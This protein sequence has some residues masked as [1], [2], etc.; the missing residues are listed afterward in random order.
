[1]SVSFDHVAI[2]A[3][4]EEAA[5]QFLGK[6]L[7]LPVER[8]GPE[9]EMF[10]LRLAEGRQVLFQPAERFDPV[11]VAFRVS[12]AELALVVERLR[13]MG[14]AFGNDPEAPTNM[15]VSDPLGGHGRVY[16]VDPNR[17]LFEVCA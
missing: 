5:A 10:C 2:P 4:D 3:R 8:D 7:D 13:S 17:H 1:M 12:P 9:D 11:H 6:V 16:F 14:I 15:L